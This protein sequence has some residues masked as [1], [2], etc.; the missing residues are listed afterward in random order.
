MKVVAFS[1]IHNNYNQLK[2]PSADLVVC[3]GDAT[4]HGSTNEIHAFID[5]FSSLEHKIKIFVPGNHDFACQKN[6][7]Y[8]AELCKSKNI[9]LSTNGFI[10]TNDKILYAFSWTPY[11][12]DWAFNGTD[13]LNTADQYKGP[14]LK[15]M[16]YQLYNTEDT[17][18]LLISHGPPLGI[19]DKN[20]EG[21]NCGSIVLKDLVETK[22][23]IKK[24][25]FGHIHEAYG[26]KTI[27]SCTFYNV[28]SLNR[29]YILTNPPVEFEI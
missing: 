27:N 6:P 16:L 2:L 23:N 8:Y 21:T 10:Y 19:L 17:V 11:F 20:L 15:N 14:N 29:N 5:W 1:D 18:D 7:A 3:A 25:V 26:T 13:S 24:M 12:Y 28:S 4:G 22:N 9:V